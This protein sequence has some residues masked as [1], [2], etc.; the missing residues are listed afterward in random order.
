MA[1]YCKTCQLGAN[2]IYCTECLKKGE[3][4]GHNLA[5]VK[6]EGG[7]CDCGDWNSLRKAGF[8][9]DHTGEDIDI[10]DLKDFALREAATTA[11]TK[12]VKALE[13]L[14]LQVETVPTHYPMIAKQAR[15]LRRLAEQ[16]N[17]CL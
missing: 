6:N 2:A 8:C 16:N 1:W 4:A 12:A 14:C 17:Y 3:H 13:H 7:R 11:I 10:F 15:L 5:S 9:S